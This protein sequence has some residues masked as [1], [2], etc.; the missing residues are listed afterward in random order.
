MLR[1]K[2]EMF[3]SDFISHNGQTADPLNPFTKAM[4]QISGKRK[5]TDADFAQLADIEYR[6]GLYVEQGRVVIPSRVLEASIAEAARKSKE[7]KLALSG[8]FVDSDAVLDVYDGGPLT[9]D[10]LVKSE[11]HRLC[12]GVRVGQS[13]VMRTRP[14]FKNVECSFECSINPEVANDRQ[15]KGWLENMVTMVGVGDWRPR[16]GRGEIHAIEQITVPLRAAA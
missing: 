4:K 6:A 15:L 13:R 2:V 1:F 3:L 10:E 9:I 7:G 12:V 11:V 14:H 8:L 5:K 16:H